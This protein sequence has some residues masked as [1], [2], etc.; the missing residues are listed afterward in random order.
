MFS[1]IPVRTLGLALFAVCAALLAVGL[2]L[3]HIKGIE[4]CPMCIMQ[5][6]A[7]LVCGLLGLIAGLHNPGRTGLVV[8]SGLLAVSALAGAGVAARQSWMQWYPP[9]VSECGPGLE[10]MLES[11]P[12]SSALP[13]IFRGAGDCSAIDWTLFGLTIANWSFLVFATILVSLGVYLLQRRKA[14]Y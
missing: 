3:Q 5:R 6:Y 10:Y 9:A 11:F 13:M 4:P 7:M 1:R 8:Y 14:G 12:L 2:Y